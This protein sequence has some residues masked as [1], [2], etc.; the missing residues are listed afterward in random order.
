MKL[1]DDRIEMLNTISG[2]YLKLGIVSDGLKRYIVFTCLQDGK[3][4]IEEIYVSM[5]ASTSSNIDI[6]LKKVEHDEEWKAIFKYITT[7]TTVL[8]KKRLKK[9]FGDVLPY[10]TTIE[11]KNDRK[12]GR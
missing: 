11:D 2:E 10:N 5:N 12:K 4:Y 8:S 3:I 9:I 1:L 6:R 7:E